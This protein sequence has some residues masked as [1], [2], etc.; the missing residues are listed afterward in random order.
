MSAYDLDSVKQME[1][2]CREGDVDTLKLLIRND[3]NVVNTVL[4]ELRWTP[5]HIASLIGNVDVVEIL[6]RNGANMK[7]VLWIRPLKMQ[8]V[9]L[10]RTL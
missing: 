2:A 1:Q 6:I 5:L 7:V 4:N 10:I 8:L 9:L 3:V